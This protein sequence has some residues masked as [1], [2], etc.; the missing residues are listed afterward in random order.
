MS[1]KLANHKT[2]HF[3]QF[4][5]KTNDSIYRK[6]QKPLFLPFLGPFCPKSWEREFSQILD[7]R[8]KLAN[9]KMLHF[10]TFLA[11]TYD[12]ILRKKSKNPILGAFLDLFPHFSKNENFPEISGSVTFE[13]LS[14]PNYMQNIRKKYWTN[15]EKS[16]LLTD[17][18]TDGTGDP[19]IQKS[20]KMAKIGKTRIFPKPASW[21][22][23]TL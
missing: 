9:H 7:W 22:V 20:T 10:R 8:W 13:N 5:A 19:K 15:S 23:Y 21:P 11:K 1:R 12:S 16:A 6:S 14:K 18:L 17:W 2:L 4:L 3:R